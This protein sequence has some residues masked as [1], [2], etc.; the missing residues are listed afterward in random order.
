MRTGVKDIDGA[1]SITFSWEISPQT[2]VSSEWA[3]QPSGLVVTGDAGLGLMTSAML[4]GGALGRIYLVSNRI[5]TN[6]GVEHVQTALIRVDKVAAAFA[7]GAPRGFGAVVLVTAEASGAGI[8]TSLPAQGHAALALVPPR[9]VGG[10][11]AGAAAGGSRR[12]RP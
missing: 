1:L 9:V 4:T 5:S 6:A 10:G 2:V 12:R 11:L 3:V 7:P 8:S